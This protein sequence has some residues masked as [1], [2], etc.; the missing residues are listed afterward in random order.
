M[1]VKKFCGLSAFRI[2]V[3]L[4]FRLLDL[5]CPL[6]DSW[7]ALFP[8]GFFTLGVLRILFRF[9]QTG[10][11]NFLARDLFRGVS[12]PFRIGLDNF[13]AKFCRFFR[14]LDFGLQRFDPVDLA[15]VNFPAEVSLEFSLPIGLA[16]PLVFDDFDLVREAHFSPDFDLSIFS[17]IFFCTTHK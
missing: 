3:G 4:E 11:R 2:F 8:V 1:S 6:I 16:T 17:C 7:L 15:A 14:S 9:V 12:A 10:F 13:G 5:A